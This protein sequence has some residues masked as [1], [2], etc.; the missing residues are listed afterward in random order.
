MFQWFAD[1]L[2]RETGGK[3]EGI[4]VVV[5]DHWRNLEGRQT[6]IHCALY[7]GIPTSIDLHHVAPKP[8]VWQGPGRLTKADYFA[9]ANARNTALGLAPDGWIAFVDDLSV[10]MP[11]WLAAVREAMQGNY[12]ACGAYRKVKDMV[13][14]GGELKSFT[15]HPPGLDP[16]WSGGSSDHAKPCDGAWL[17]GCSLVAPVEAFLQI[18]GY[19]EVCDGMGYEDCVTGKAIERNGWSIR[20]DR[21]ML[22]YESEELHTQTPIMRREDPCRGD[23]NANPRD[24]MSHSMLRTFANVRRFDNFFGPEG[25]SGLRDRVLRGE[26]FPPMGIPEH[27]WFDSKPLRELPED[28]AV[29]EP[30]VPVVTDATPKDAAPVTTEQ[31]TQ[32]VPET[33]ASDA[34]PT[35]EPQPAPITDAQPEP[36]AVEDAAPAPEPEPEPAPAPTPKK[37]AAKPKAKAKPK[38]AAPEDDDVEL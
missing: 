5:V 12:I 7:R 17:F 26:P 27:R 38:P 1:S 4:R 18:N 25:L 16:R 8:T 33:P 31:G 11:G 9:A 22:T 24:D 15:N 36:S 19:P 13:V 30:V 34:A 2:R 32:P 21:R 28:V 29:A 6:D 10:L 37:A 14:E 3:Y 35:P 20:Y 23:P